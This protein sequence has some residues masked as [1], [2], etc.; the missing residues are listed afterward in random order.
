MADYGSASASISQDQG[1]SYQI[2]AY[3][4]GLS[5]ISRWRASPATDR[6]S[7]GR[8]ASWQVAY[9]SFSTNGTYAVSGS[10]PIWRMELGKPFLWHRP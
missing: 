1:G 4:G 10:P 7:A 8:V 2:G 9:G 5:L 6:G 3:A